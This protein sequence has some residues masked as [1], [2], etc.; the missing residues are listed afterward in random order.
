LLHHATVENHELK[1]PGNAYPSLVLRNET[2]ITLQLA[3]K[4]EEFA[5]AGLPIVFAEHL[6]AEEASF[7]DY[8][9]NGRRIQQ[10]MQEILGSQRDASGKSAPV[11]GHGSVRFVD[12]AT[13][14]PGVLQAELKVGPNLQFATPEPSI[15]FQQFDAGSTSFFFFRNPKGESQD[16]RVTLGAG[17]RIPQVW[18][19]WTGEVTE[20]PVYRSESGS[21]TLDIHL[22]PY[23]S[24]LIGLAES[25]EEEHAV[26]TNFQR[27]ERTSDGLFGV[28]TEP[29]TYDT[30]FSG[31]KDKT[32]VISAKEIPLALT[33]GPNWDLNL[34]GNDKDGKEWSERLH[35][36]PLRDWSLSQNLRYFSGH[37]HYSLDVQIAEPYLRPGLALE[38]DLGE[39]HDVAE[40]WINNK[41]VASLL[42]R[43]YS[44]DV[45]PYLKAGSN[46]F[47]IVVT[48]TLRNRLVGDGMSGDPHFV[49]FQRR[50]F[51]MPS[52]LIG[53]VRILPE[54]R[55]KLR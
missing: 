38:L 3:E 17:R 12:D 29:G 7:K 22:N 46:H 49:M 52:G 16:A 37:G 54:A 14:V 53:P 40:V 2:K 26:H 28:A 25:R 1:T 13:A 20:A 24:E 30:E 55:V 33:L 39:V 31:G 4:L 15:F 42:M 21:V 45:A 41:K 19:P 18:D 6:P 51:F 10:I 36:A 47:E 34:V 50:V 35:A 48:N 43:P 5:R 32:S 23:G 8:E 44:V 11:Q 27:L 9:S